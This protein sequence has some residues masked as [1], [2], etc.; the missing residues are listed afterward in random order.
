MISRGVTP[1]VIHN[2]SDLN[3][4][5]IMQYV[6]IPAEIHPHNALNGAKISAEALSRL[7]YNRNLLSEFEKYPVTFPKS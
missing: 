1:P 5:R 2:H 4:D 7:L 6:G 3:S